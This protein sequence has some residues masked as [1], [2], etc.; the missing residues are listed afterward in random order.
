ML[1]LSELR[2]DLRKLGNKAFLEAH[3][4]PGL[5]LRLPLNALFDATELDVGEG[6]QEEDT[7]VVTVPKT[8]LPE[9][10]G[11]AP[12]LVA[13]VTQSGRHQFGSII[14]LGRAKNCDIRL[15]LSTIS[16]MHAVF[17]D[18]AGSWSVTHSGATNGVFV[19]QVAVEKDR[20]VAL[21]DGDSLSFGPGVRGH[22]YGPEALLKFLG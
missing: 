9:E 13:W 6:D 1:R 4:A 21:R 10:P 15:P 19:N 12:E 17:T 2:D 3:S 7:V 5:V 16:K 18:A 8:L 22:F 11:K 14:T 20:K